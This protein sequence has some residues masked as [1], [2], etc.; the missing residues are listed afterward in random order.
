MRAASPPR[1]RLTINGRERIVE[2]EPG[3]PLLWLLRDRLGLLGTRYGCGLGVCGSC[4]VLEG[5]T[6]V[7][8]CQIDIARAAGRAFTTIEGLSPDG[9]HPVQL[10][11]LEEDVAQCG[12]CQSGMILQAVSL[13]ARNPDPSDAEIDLAFFDLL[14]RCGTYVRVRR[15]VQ[16]AAAAARGRTP[17]T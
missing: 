17:T 11:W 15:A 3:T 14:C 13:L 8:S 4:T 2:A 6:T 16:R 5:E 10:A 9:T 7:R 1:F 12:Y